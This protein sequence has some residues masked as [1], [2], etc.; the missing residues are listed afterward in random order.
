MD[1]ERETDS[2]PARVHREIENAFQC[3]RFTDRRDCPWCSYGDRQR[4]EESSANLY[5]RRD[6]TKGNVAKS[7]R[8]STDR[9]EQELHTTLSRGSYP[10]LHPVPLRIAKLDRAAGTHVVIVNVNGRITLGDGT[11]AL[12]DTVEDLAKLG[13]NRIGLNLEGVT[14]IDAAGLGE[15]VRLYRKLHNQ[16]G[17]LNLLAP[18]RRVRELLHITKLDTVF[19]VT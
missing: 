8:G 19:S 7:D 5:S 6:G 10:R 16:G 15:L 13:H 1:T 14:Q 4:A 17:D 3:A 11:A 9:R 12:R 18:P 2:A